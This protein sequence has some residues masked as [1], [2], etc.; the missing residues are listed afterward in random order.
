[1]FD[2][3]V[4]KVVVVFTAVWA[5]ICKRQTL[6][7]LFTGAIY[8]CVCDIGCAKGGY[9]RENTFFAHNHFCMCNETQLWYATVCAHMTTYIIYTYILWE[10]VS[11]RG[12]T[13]RAVVVGTRVVF[14]QRVAHEDKNKY[15][16]RQINDRVIGFSRADKRDFVKAGA[17]TMNYIY[18]ICTIMCIGRRSD[19]VVSRRCRNI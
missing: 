3:H 13:G 12:R 16:P 18:I 17:N 5:A 19:S 6:S 9:S 14:S 7:T 8:V 1:V 2:V 10:G 4:R 15:V 11:G